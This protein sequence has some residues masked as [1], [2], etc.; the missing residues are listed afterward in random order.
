MKRICCGTLAWI[1]LISSL[2]GC[3]SSTKNN[4]ASHTPNDVTRQQ[5]LVDDTSYIGEHL[6][7]DFNDPNLEIAK[8]DNG[9]Y[10]VQIGIYRLAAFYDGIGEL[11]AEGMNFTATDPAGNPI[12]GV[13]TIEGQTA[14]V[15]FTSS[16]WIYLE[17]GASFQYTKSSNTPNIWGD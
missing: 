3:G 2:T 7:Y 14:T 11:T 9:K 16:T 4:E 6:D 15:T 1:I 5:I 10:I 12:S 13:V 17:N 8:G